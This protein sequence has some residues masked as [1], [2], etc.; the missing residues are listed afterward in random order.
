MPDSY[1]KSL[2][3]PL[4]EDIAHLKGAGEYALAIKLIDR[5]LSG[6]IPQMLRTRLE[7][8]RMFLESAC[9]AITA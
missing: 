2:P 1:L 9:R 8:E 6:D 7:T 5:R 4:P 3:C